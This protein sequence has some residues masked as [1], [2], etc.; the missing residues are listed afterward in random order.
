MRKILGLA[1]LVAIGTSTLALASW[2]RSGATNTYV[3]YLAA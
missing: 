2:E 3:H 1:L